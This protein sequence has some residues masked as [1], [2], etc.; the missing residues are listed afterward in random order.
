[1]QPARIVFLDHEPPLL[2]RLDRRLA[3][4]LGGLFEI[5]FLSV[6]REVSQGHDQSHANH[7]TTASARNQNPQRQLKFP[8]SN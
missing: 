3:A 8:N 7:G 4:R 6:S 2:R 5:A 1:M